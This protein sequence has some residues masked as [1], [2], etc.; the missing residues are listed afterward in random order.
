L[1]THGC[2]RRQYFHDS[3][4]AS[5][6]KNA[7]SICEKVTI[8]LCWLYIHFHHHHPHPQYLPMLFT[9]LHVIDAY[10]CIFQIHVFLFIVYPNK[11]ITSIFLTQWTHPLVEASHSWGYLICVKFLLYP[12]PSPWVH[13]K[14]QIAIPP[15]ALSVAFCPPC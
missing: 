10:N 12:S 3:Y 1:R 7:P 2:V 11:L 13:M 5:I 4:K 9:M 8:H 14:V 15:A 6:Q